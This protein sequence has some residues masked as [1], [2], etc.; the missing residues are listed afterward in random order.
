MNSYGIVDYGY[1]DY[2]N[3]YLKEKNKLAFYT[4]EFSKSGYTIEDVKNDIDKNKVINVDNKK[5]YLKEALR[6]SDIVTLTIGIN[7]FLRKLY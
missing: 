5:V 2:I 6:E 4:K 7:D 1:P 3:D